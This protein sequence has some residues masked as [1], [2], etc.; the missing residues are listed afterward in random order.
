MCTDVNFIQSVCTRSRY[1]RKRVRIRSCVRLSSFV[2]TSVLDRW[3]CVKVK[4]SETPSGAPRDHAAP[5][6]RSITNR[7]TVGATPV[8]SPRVHALSMPI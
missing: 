2:H 5:K 3:E 6:L 4:G 8:T 7:V 1:G